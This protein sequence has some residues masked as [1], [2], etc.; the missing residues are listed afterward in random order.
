MSLPEPVLAATLEPAPAL[1]AVKTA[2][3]LLESL[4][5]TSVALERNELHGQIWAL[6]RLELELKRRL[7]ASW[8][9]APPGGDAA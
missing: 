9:I 4:A 5:D 7:D 6:R 3:R 2:R 8:G 1:A